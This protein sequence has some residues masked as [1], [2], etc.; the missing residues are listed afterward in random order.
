LIILFFLIAQ[1]AFLQRVD[2]FADYGTISRAIYMLVALLL[3]YALVEK[4]G[5][6]VFDYF[7]YTISIIGMFQIFLL[8]D[9]LST[10]L[11]GIYGLYVHRDVSL[12]GNVRFGGTYIWPYS[13]GSY[14]GLLWAFI[15]CKFILSNHK[16]RL[17]FVLF[18]VFFLLLTVFNG[19]RSVLLALVFS[20]LWLSMLNII[21]ANSPKKLLKTFIFF[22]IIAILAALFSKSHY[23]ERALDFS[24]SMYEARL[25]YSL[26]V[27]ELFKSHKHLFL[28]GFGRNVF[29][30]KGAE[31]F[32]QIVF[33]YGIFGTL[34]VIYYPIKYFFK[35]TIYLI[36]NKISST[37]SSYLWILMMNIW[38]VYIFILSTS[39]ALFLNHRFMMIY[40]FAMGIAFRYV[41]VQPTP[42]THNK[43]PCGRHEK[44]CSGLYGTGFKTASVLGGIRNIQAGFPE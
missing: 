5:N 28:F 3:G 8:I 36:K 27:F 7:L 20:M 21:S 39:S 22:F 23:S 17:P 11:N 24:E 4:Y 26:D 37:S 15:A 29:E 32:L 2:N 42:S 34:L 33:R 19:S 35:S 18:F 12:F 1:T 43:W 6:K 14:I 31:S 13:L 16:Y 9:Y 25:I 10:G 40:Y 30:Y 38:T 41:S 44:T